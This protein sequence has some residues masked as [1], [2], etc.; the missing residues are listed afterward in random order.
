MAYFEVH[1]DH[2][3]SAR[4]GASGMFQV[5]SITDENGNDRTAIVD[6]GIHYSD[7]DSLALDIANALGLGPS[8][9]ELVEV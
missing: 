1:L 7:L 9:I 5:I 3:T 8:E 2:E 4:A 6:Q